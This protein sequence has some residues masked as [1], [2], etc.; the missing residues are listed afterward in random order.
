[1]ETRAINPKSVAASQGSYAHGIVSDG[2][3]RT[4]FISG[5][6]PVISG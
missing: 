3:T 2:A 6:I 4:L 1:M 5:Q